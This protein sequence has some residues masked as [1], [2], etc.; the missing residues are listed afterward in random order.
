MIIYNNVLK[1]S[2]RERE[3]ERAHADVCAISDNLQ[4]TVYDVW[5]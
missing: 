3:R 1:V 4:S 2:G 5:H